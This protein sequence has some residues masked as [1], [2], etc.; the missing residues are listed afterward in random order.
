MQILKYIIFLSFQQEERVENYI[1][2][3][4]VISFYYSKKNL[5]KLQILPKV[6]HCPW[7]V[8]PPV[9]KGNKKS[10]SDSEE[11]M[12]GASAP[13]PASS[14]PPALFDILMSVVIKKTAPSGLPPLV[15]PPQK[16]VTPPDPCIKGQV[17]H[18]F[19]SLLHPCLYTEIPP[20]YTVIIAK[21][22]HSYPFENVNSKYI[23]IDPLDNIYI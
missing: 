18:V 1:Y 10:S 19:F 2:F 5:K 21:F 23:L 12:L 13:P 4:I 22:Q 3:L 7:I 17:G 6:K 15:P 16:K 9:V 8:I 11:E 20:G 14:S